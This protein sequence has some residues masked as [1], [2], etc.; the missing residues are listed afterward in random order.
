MRKKGAF[1][2]LTK[3]SRSAIIMASITVGVKLNWQSSAL[4][5]RRLKVRALS[6]LFEDRL[7]A[8]RRS[9]LLSV[10]CGQ[11][12]VH[13][14]VSSSLSKSPKPEKDCNFASLRCR[15]R[16]VGNDVRRWINALVMQG[17]VLRRAW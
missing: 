7:I 11:T 4:Q 17:V 16:S 14:L 1:H 3:C 5:K 2:D 13:V 10:D 9:S 8:F 15:I 6:P 12:D